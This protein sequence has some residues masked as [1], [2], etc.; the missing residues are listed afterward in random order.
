ME[1]LLFC[2]H[3][4]FLTILFVGLISEGKLCEGVNKEGTKYD[5]NLINELL[6][7]GHDAFLNSIM[8]HQLI[9]RS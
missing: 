8:C 9:M 7:N 5:N 3:I 6:A 1:W 2:D 4:M